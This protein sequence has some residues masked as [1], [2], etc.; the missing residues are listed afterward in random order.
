MVGT[1][2][3]YIPPPTPGSRGDPFATPAPSMRQTDPFEDSISRGS[4]APSPG[5]MTPRY[6]PSDHS[7][8]LQQYGP[9]TEYAAGR[10]S[11]SDNPYKRV[12]TAWDPRISRGEIDPNDIADDG[13]D[14]MME[15][16]SRKRSVL[17]MRTQS[18]SVSGGTAAGAAAGGG[19]LGTLGGFVGKSNAS[20]VGNRD[21]S[22]QYGPVAKGASGE[23]E[24]DVEKSEWLTKQTSGRK[25]LRWIVGTLIVLALIGAI[26]GGVIG[27]IKA[28]SDDSKDKGPGSTGGGGE[29]ASEDD[30]RGDL[31]KDSPEIR[32]LMGNPDLHKVFPGM[33]YLPYGAQYPECLKWPPSQNNVTRDLAVLSQLTDVIR[34]YG[35]DCN[36]TEMVLHSIDRLQLTDMKVWLGVWLGDNDT[37]ND[38]QLQAMNSI[39]DNSDR[40]SFAGVVI[41]N[42]VLYREDLTETELAKI[43]GD[44]KKN[45][46]A[47]KIDLPIAT[48]DLG[49]KWTA[50]LASE[51]DI[52]MSNIH[53]F[54]S[55]T[56]AEKAAGWTWD[57]W[58][59]KDALI[60]TPADPKKNIISEVGW[61]SGGGNHCGAATCTS[62]TQGSIAGIDEMNTF[63]DNWVCQS[64]ANGTDYFWYVLCLCFSLSFSLCNLF[65]PYWF[66]R[67]GGQR[68][69]NQY[70]DRKRR[71]E[72]YDQPWQKQFNKGDR[73]WEDKW[74]LMGIDRVLKDGLKIPDC[75]GKTISR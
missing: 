10:G 3:P 47:Q 61:P 73:N 58:K 46:T 44:V 27:G 66:L 67:E 20:G 29:S 36:Q 53:P 16:V 50:A 31:D 56:T 15:P 43:L 74:G 18:S 33:A 1:D 14:G 57:F 21:P 38:R 2:T 17:G 39:V 28:K 5:R 19:I 51:V 69:E 32:K 40:K 45:F 72:A 25:R 75:G 23:G 6:Q 11:Y 42:E 35:T 7:I 49:D 30:G 24:G 70:T 8:P 60:A 71:F 68:N 22:G 13:D 48:S 34:L 37:T 12:S 62:D 9:G 55:G 63:M 59:N 52:I 54:F 65:L 26:V 64:L 4:G 41:G